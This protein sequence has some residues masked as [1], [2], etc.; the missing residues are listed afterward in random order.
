[1]ATT[2]GCGIGDEI[3]L[4]VRRQLTLGSDPLLPPGDRAT[5]YP[6]EWTMNTSTH[7]SIGLTR[8]QSV[9]SAVGAKTV[10]QAAEAKA[11]ELGVPVIIVVVD[12]GGDL[13]ALLG[14]D[15]A[16]KGA[17]QWAIDK[18]VTAA[19]FRTPTH[20]LGQA[21]SDFPAAIASF[22]GQPHATLVPAGYPLV[23]DGAVVGAV[24]ASGGTP[25]Q[26]QAIAEAGAGALGDAGA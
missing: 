4:I 23:I 12:D 15:G 7:D 8:A 6:K 9:I 13:K 21:M 11:G 26:D 25:E 20:I 14:M 5:R 3:T 1:V 10:M 18:A 22:M 17:I 16:P 19:S 2:P 24:G